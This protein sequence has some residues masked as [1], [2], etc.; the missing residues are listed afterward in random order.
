LQLQASDTVWLGLDP[1]CAGVFGVPIGLLF[2]FLGSK[3]SSNA[4]N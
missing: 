4:K 2:G 1:V 3:L